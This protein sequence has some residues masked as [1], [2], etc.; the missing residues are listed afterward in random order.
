MGLLLLVALVVVAGHLGD[1]REFLDLARRA[2]PAWLVL[3]LGSQA[4]TYATE[5]GVWRSVLR[6]AEAGRPMAELYGL[7]I[8]A[9]FT[10]QAVPT[11]GLAGS[12]VVVRTLQARGVPHPVA[13]AAVLVDLVGFYAAYGLAVAVALAVLRAHHDLSWA[14]LVTAAVFALL[15]FAIDGGALWIAAPERR[16]PPLLARI[17]PLERTVASLS[18]ADPALVRDPRLLA[19]AFLLR[20]GNFALDAFTLWTCLRAVGEHTAPGAALAAFVVGCLAR[21]L[22][23]VPGGLGTFEAATVGGLALFGTHVEP[24]LTATLLFRGLS[25][26]LPMLPGFWLGPR[27]AGHRPGEAA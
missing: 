3:A 23:I 13:L 19:R 4:L 10:N 5:A 26:W 18:E 7:S 24:A 6:R 15:G 9:L 25:F 21:T 27:L 2:E 12:F 16:L 14:I 1:G 22:G 8:V 17:R 11:A 20:V